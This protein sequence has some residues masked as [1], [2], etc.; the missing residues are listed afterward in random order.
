MIYLSDNSNRRDLEKMK[1]KSF[2]CNSDGSKLDF[3]IKIRKPTAKQA[4]FIS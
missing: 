2:F 4:A 1:R 3:L